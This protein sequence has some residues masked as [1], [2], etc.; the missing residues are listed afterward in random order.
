MSISSAGLRSN[1][2][3]VQGIV[4]SRDG[5][6]ELGSD[7]TAVVCSICCSGDTGGMGV[8][9]VSGVSGVTV[10]GSVVAVWLAFVVGS[11]VG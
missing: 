11:T 1:N 9:V 10:G 2:A 6:D 4:G 3:V 5:T 7:S 8:A